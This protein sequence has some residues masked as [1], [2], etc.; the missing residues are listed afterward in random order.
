MFLNGKENKRKKGKV[1]SLGCSSKRVCRERKRGVFG[2]E[3]REMV[4]GI[5]IVVGKVG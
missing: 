3:E 1:E 4:V 2:C 5:Y